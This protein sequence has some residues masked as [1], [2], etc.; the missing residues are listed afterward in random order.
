MGKS[1]VSYKTLTLTNA[2]V[3]DQVAQNILREAAKVYVLNAYKYIKVDTGMSRGALVPLARALNIDIPITPKS[4]K[5]GK[6]ISA[7]AD[8]SFFDFYKIGT[9]NTFE[10]ST[11]VFQYY[12]NEKYP[13]RSNYGSPWNSLEQGSLKAKEYL[14]STGTQMAKAVELSWST[15][16][17]S[18]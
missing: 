5:T 9:V 17:R 4:K 6:G 15:K 18:I 2:E 3:L 7:G 11:S 12:L 16:V 1:G 14:L 8:K 13:L 10:W